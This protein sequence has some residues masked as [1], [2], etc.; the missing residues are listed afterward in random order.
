MKNHVILFEQFKNH[1]NESASAHYVYNETETI[2][3]VMDEIPGLEEEH[4]PILF[5]DPQLYDAYVG[6]KNDGNMTQEELDK[7][8]PFRIDAYV[9]VSSYSHSSATRWD[10]SETEMEFDVEIEIEAF[11][12]QDRSKWSEQKKSIVASIV[13]YYDD[14]ARDDAYNDGDLELEADEDD[15][16]DYDYDYYGDD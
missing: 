16:G 4:L 11:G 12:N 3:D 6:P 9:D 14:I 7:I 2:W 1:L 5:T 13:S 8:K 10:P 15:D